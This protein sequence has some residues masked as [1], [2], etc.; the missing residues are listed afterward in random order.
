[1]NILTFV[2]TFFEVNNEGSL[3]LFLVNRRQQPEDL[4]GYLDF[5]TVPCSIQISSS[6]LFYSSHTGRNWSVDSTDWIDWTIDEV[7]IMHV[8]V[9]GGMTNEE[10][11]RTYINDIVS[12]H[13]IRSL[14]FSFDVSRSLYVVHAVT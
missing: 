6:S 7:A 2:W 9:S 12:V 1:M 8:D 4:Y 5:I 14:S 13:F 3:F 10:R 11:A